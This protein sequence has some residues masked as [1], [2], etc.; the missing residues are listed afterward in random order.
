M[1]INASLILFLILHLI[2]SQSSLWVKD[3]MLHKPTLIGVWP[4]VEILSPRIAAMQPTI[5]LTD[6]RRIPGDKDADT[7][8]F[9]LLAAL[10]G[11]GA[12]FI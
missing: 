7:V 1:W 5:L 3:N 12:S 6:E 4:V 2:S 8:G 11:E 10:S 9:F